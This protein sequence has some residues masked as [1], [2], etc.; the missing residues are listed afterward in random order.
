MG[1]TASI[2]LQKW[3]HVLA[4]MRQTGILHC[5]AMHVVL[6]F[7]NIF[8]IPY[9]CY[10]FVW[11]C[12]FPKRVLKGWGGQNVWIILSIVSSQCV[13][14]TGSRQISRWAKN[15]LW[16]AVYKI[17][18]HESGNKKKGKLEATIKLLSS[19]PEA[20]WAF[21]MGR[22]DKQHINKQ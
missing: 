20:D 4:T 6:L 15:A 16:D 7:Y 22:S 13:S 18:N 19:K 9:P 8:T 21:P 3:V 14:L 11:W 5:F 12:F 10:G 17:C 1:D 2:I